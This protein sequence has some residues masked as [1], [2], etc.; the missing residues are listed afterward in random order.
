MRAAAGGDDFAGRFDGHRLLVDAG[1]DQGI[2]YVGERHEPRG[3][4]DGLAG[5][6]VRVAAAVP[7]FV[8]P[9]GDFLGQAEKFD[10][11]GGF[12]LG[13]FDGFAAQPRVGA[14]DR[15]FFR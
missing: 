5:E 6:A 7:F 11:S 12:P 3:E 10:R 9:M 2:E 15:P 4:G 14:H 8:V 13:H 1:G